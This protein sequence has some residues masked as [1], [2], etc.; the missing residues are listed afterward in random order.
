MAATRRDLAGA[1][2]PQ[3]ELTT[4]PVHKVVR[5]VATDPHSWEGA[6]R[7][8][9]AEATKTIRDLRRAKVTEFDTVISDG[10]VALYRVKLEVTFRLDR[11]RPASEPGL[12]ALE[13]KRYLVVANLTLSSPELSQAV[14]ERIGRGPAEFHV[15]VPATYSDAQS[16][17]RRAALM[18]DPLT[19]YIAPD[20]MMFAEH[21]ED[22]MAAAEA[23]LADYVSRIEQAGARYPVSGEIGEADPIAAISRVLGRASFDEII[24]STLPAGISRWVG[25]DLP[26]RVRRT[27]RLPLVHITATEASEN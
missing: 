13:V 1:R 18:S 12:P 20:L 14:D 11:L 3:E 19:G 7:A 9:V 8:A 4:S 27:F 10:A 6:T 24:L 16:A 17:A 22:A 21:D 15:L 25:M 23:R 5:L 2:D 26:S